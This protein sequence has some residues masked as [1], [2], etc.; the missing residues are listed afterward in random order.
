[1]LDRRLQTGLLVLATSW[2]ALA[3][4]AGPGSAGMFRT[5][6]I[7]LLVV[8]LA[9]VVSHGLAGWI[10]KRFGVVTGV[11]YIVLG[12][13]VGPITGLLDEST[14]GKL[15]SALVLGTGSLGL[16]AGLEIRARR[17]SIATGGGFAPAVIVSILTFL[18]VAGAPAALLVYF[19]G[20]EGLLG[21]V[22][23]LVALGAIALVADSRPIR[24]LGTYLDARGAGGFV[25]ARI[26]RMCS[27]IAVVVFGI[28]F[29]IGKPFVDV[30]GYSLT[31]LGATVA[32]L[33]VHLALGGVL[34]VLFLGFLF[35]DY[36]EER[37]LT[38]LIGMVIFASGIAFYLGLSPIFVCFVVGWGLGWSRRA[39]QLEPMLVS[40]ERPLYIVLF[41][42]AGAELGFGL[43]AWSYLLFV[44]FLVLR[45]WGRALGG[46]VASRVVASAARLPPMG[47]VTYF[48]GGLSV[49]MALNFSSVF[50]HLP[51]AEE[52][53]FAI[54]LAILFSEVSAYR[55]A[56]RWFID[57]TN[58]STQR[59]SD[60]SGGQA[61][62]P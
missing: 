12:A 21:H 22:P 31:P 62:G 5:I 41:F 23:Y 54:I 15:D 44:P 59:S 29:C 48:P 2:P 25:A 33:L 7:L 57:A 40:V 1:M 35:R 39:D 55:P 37:L 52:A 27:A 9:Y 46:W 4:A 14:L 13:I 34:A 16:L 43:P 50:G 61:V 24:A 8:S 6:L 19:G 45:W 18:L 36:E 38:V 51:F 11:E 26:A 32:W 10:S 60:E 42:F 47:A 58:V 53:Y 30:L 56:R 49:A 28:A 17:S 20:L 3:Y